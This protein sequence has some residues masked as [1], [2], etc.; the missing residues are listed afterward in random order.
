MHLRDEAAGQVGPLARWRC[1]VECTSSSTAFVPSQGKGALGLSCSPPSM[2]V[3]S[4]GLYGGHPQGLL[5]ACASAFP[6]FPWYRQ[7][8]RSDRQ[9]GLHQAVRWPDRSPVARSRASLTSHSQRPS[10]PAEAGPTDQDQRGA[11]GAARP[12]RPRSQRQPA[13]RPGINSRGLEP[14]HPLR[15]APGQARPAMEASLGWRLPRT[16]R[17]QADQRPTPDS[18]QAPRRRLDQQPRCV[19]R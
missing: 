3:L 14:L 10:T 4:Q 13:G 7:V 5:L 9:R 15:P 11:P 17:P 18:S 12:G 16:A 6:K 19:R 8:A 1:D 2:G